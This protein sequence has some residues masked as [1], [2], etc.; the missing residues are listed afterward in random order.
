MTG[1]PDSR[2]QREI[3]H[4]GAGADLQRSCTHVEPF[5][6]GRG[7]GSAECGV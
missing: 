2:K 4:G 3:A 5:D 6:A 7:P 1:H